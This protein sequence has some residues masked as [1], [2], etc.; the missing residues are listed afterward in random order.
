MRHLYELRRQTKILKEIMKMIIG[1]VS[2]G[3]NQIQLSI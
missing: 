3:L 1:Y 2:H